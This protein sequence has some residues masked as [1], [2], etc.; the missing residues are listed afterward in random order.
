[1]ASDTSTPRVRSSPVSSGVLAPAAK[2]SAIV[3][4]RLVIS[5][6][7]LCCC[8][9]RRKRP[10]RATVSTTSAVM[11]RLSLT[12][13]GTRIAACSGDTVAAGSVTAGTLDPLAGSSTLTRPYSP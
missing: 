11:S 7:R 10:T 4:P 13:S 8:W 2:F 1:M 9:R 12:L 3:S 6:V 5:A